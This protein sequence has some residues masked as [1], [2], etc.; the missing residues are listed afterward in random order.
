[1]TA[2]DTHDP[3]E[4][5]SVLSRLR[6]RVD[7]GGRKES[8][9]GRGNPDEAHGQR[10]QTAAER[11]SKRA[12]R[13]AAAPLFFGK[14]MLLFGALVAAVLV[15]DLFFYIGVALI[16]ND[17]SLTGGAPNHLAREAGQE[18]EKT[19][20]GWEMPDNVQV[21]LDER[22]CWCILIGYDG[23][24]AWHTPNAPKARCAPTI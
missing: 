2:R 24:V 12:R 9:A 10:S 1:M 22:G 11:R 5:V 20:D 8:T 6:R 14:Q 19:D 16:E 18:L 3:S 17:A 23:K 15:L 13:K 21:A 7:K 4:R